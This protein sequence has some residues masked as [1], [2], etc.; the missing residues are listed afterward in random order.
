MQTITFRM[1]KQQGPIGNYAQCLWLEHDERYQKNTYIYIYILKIYILYDW[2]TL[3]HSRNRHY[4]VNELYFNKKF[5][6]HTHR[7]TTITKLNLTAMEEGKTP[8]DSG[9]Q[10]FPKLGAQ[11]GQQSPL[12]INLSGSNKILQPNTLSYH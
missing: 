3:L 11:S 9:T 5:K 12:S 10:S 8:Q 1:D 4:T 7:S 2:V 6:K